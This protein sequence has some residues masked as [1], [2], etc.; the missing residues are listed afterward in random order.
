L[1][2]ERTNVDVTG[3]NDSH[4]AHLPGKF[5]ERVD[6]DYLLGRRPDLIVMLAR[7]PQPRG[8]TDLWLTPDG[9]LFEDANFRASYGFARRYE[10][11]RGY[12]L[13]AFRRHGSAAAPAEFWG[14]DDRS[15]LA[16]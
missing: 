3:L 11:N 10:F 9:V 6:V 4:M 1:L 13:I 16:Q 15:W 12:F 7:V 2:C 5:L 8:R 14:G